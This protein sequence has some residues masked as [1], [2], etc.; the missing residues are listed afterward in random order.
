MAANYDHSIL[1]SRGIFLKKDGH[2]HTHYCPHGSIESVEKYIM[3]AIKQGFTDYSITEHAPLPTAFLKSAAGEQYAI[4]TAGMRI[5]DVPTYLTEM[6]DLKK[7]YAS[8][9]NIHV[10]FEIDYAP[11]FED[12]TSAFLNE[13]GPQTDDNILS[14]HFLQGH[15]GWRAIDYCPED[16]KEGIVE[17]YRGFQEAQNAYL[18]LLLQSIKADLGPY[19]PKRIG[20]ITLCNKFERYFD[21]PTA[22]NEIGESYLKE[23][24]QEMQQR[25]LSLDLNV[26]GLAKPYCLQTYPP[27]PIVEQAKQLGINIVFGSDAHKSYEVGRYY[28]MVA[29]YLSD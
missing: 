8:Q 15:G 7:K 27:L 25:Q 6:H 11:G 22:F 29:N 16:Y 12:W 24:L 10:G 14:L 13:F 26:A 9:I 19:K 4:D 20:H 28:D 17:Y 23:I 5:E 3:Q 18:S 1:E 21:E 2:T